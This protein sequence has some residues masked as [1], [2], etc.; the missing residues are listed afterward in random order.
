MAAVISSCGEYR[1]RLE[2]T[3][4]M[5]GPVAAVIMVNPSTADAQVDDAT[6]RRVVGFGKRFGWSR[7]IV[8]NVFAFRST[9]IG[10]LALTIDPVGPKN[11]VHLRSIFQEADV[12]IAAWG[13]LGKLPQPLRHEWRNVCAIADGLGSDFKC[14]GL[15]KDGQP[16]H[17]LM[18]SYRSELVDW[19]KP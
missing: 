18:L 17:P 6:I 16:K 13:R 4:G 19:E 8:G 1:Y 10:R 5:F 15:T 7:V 2:R 11:S 12:A 14:L 3:I 9:D